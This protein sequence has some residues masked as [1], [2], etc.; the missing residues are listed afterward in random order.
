[1]PEIQLNGK[2]IATQTG[3]N[4][5]VLKNNVVMESGF[6]I[7]SG[8]TFPAGNI[9]QVVQTQDHKAFSYTNTSSNWYWGTSLTRADDSHGGVASYLN[10][11]LT[12]KGTNSNFLV[13]ANLQNAGASVA[14]YTW[15]M[16]TY[17]SVDS[18]ANPLI[19]GVPSTHGIYSNGQG[20]QSGFWQ[21]TAVDGTWYPHYTQI[22]KSSNT[23]AKGIS[24]TFKIVISTYYTSG[25][26]T[27]Y[28]NRQNTTNNGSY[29]LVPVST[30]TIYEIAS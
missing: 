20:L 9:L 10:C 24:I 5:P 22:L 12:T 17:W 11:T 27:L 25:G 18:Y 7:P 26:N 19:V 15:G 13:C 1:M 8:V 4:E 30:H 2:T 29:R 16:N 28:Y 21:D 23:I 6:S 14:G 3:T